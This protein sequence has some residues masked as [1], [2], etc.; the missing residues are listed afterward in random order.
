MIK[1]LI[2]VI[3]FAICLS[4]SYA[5]N[6]ST[7]PYPQVPRY[8]YISPDIIHCQSQKQELEVIGFEVNG[9]GYY[10]SIY[11]LYSDGSIWQYLGS[12]KQWNKIANLPN[13]FKNQ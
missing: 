12:T 8:P 10:Y 11:V 5:I 2:S 6:H 1:I 4:N 7:N 13:M 9:T 3:S